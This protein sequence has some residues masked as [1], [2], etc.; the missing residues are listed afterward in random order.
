[1]CNNVFRHPI[2]ILWLVSRQFKIVTS[3]KGASSVWPGKQWAVPSKVGSVYIRSILMRNS[4]HVWVDWDPGW[5]IMINDIKVISNF[6][7]STWKFRVINEIQSYLSISFC[8]CFSL[9]FWIRIRSK[10]ANIQA[11]FS[12]HPAMQA[13]IKLFAL[14]AS[15]CRLES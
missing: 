15:A 6:K 12:Q 2:L 1:M 10:P 5:K 3:L 14:V 11:K 7:I 13:S 9:I 8:F 4:K